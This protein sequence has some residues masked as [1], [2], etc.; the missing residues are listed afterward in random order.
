MIFFVFKKVVKLVYNQQNEKQFCSATL[1]N[2]LLICNLW[3]YGNVI[4]ENVDVDGNQ[5]NKIR[6]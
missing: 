1:V 3:K 2:I 4:M 6:I 5:C